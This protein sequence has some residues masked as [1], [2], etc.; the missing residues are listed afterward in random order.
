[1]N[2][3]RDML[4]GLGL[5]GLASTPTILHPYWGGEGAK[6]A[7]GGASLPDGSYESFGAGDQVAALV[8]EVAPGLEGPNPLLTLARRDLIIAVDL[9]WV[10]VP[11][12]RSNAEVAELGAKAG[13]YAEAKGRPGWLDEV[14]NDQQF[15]T[16]LAVEVDAWQPQATSPVAATEWES[17]GVAD[18]WDRVREGASRLVSTPSRVVGSAAVAAGRAKAQS[19]VALFLGDV[20]IYLDRR[21]DNAGRPGPITQVVIDAV[22][23]ALD[24][25]TPADPHLVLMGH[26][27]GGN[28]L[29]DIL[30]HY[31]PNLSV[32]AL[33]TVGSQ[34][35]F[36][37]EL[38]LFQS[39]D[40]SIPSPTIVK[41]ALRSGIRHWLN[42]FDRQD[43][44]SFSGRAIFDRI[45]D[46]DYSTGA[47]VLGAHTTYLE[48]PSFHRRLN[49]RLHAALVP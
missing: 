8:E 6:P 4:A 15:L 40:A 3:Q 11:P 23:Q 1:M 26:S 24:A 39:S 44:L 17:F 46:L 36:F 49:E 19:A 47:S 18:V 38:K 7:W 41:Q 25:V 12:D 45:E 5:R 20:L 28:I 37:E 29:Y 13:T 34:V 9:L 31:R 35:P 33:V 16:R 48:R 22:D 14:T 2:K 42:I 27:M 32:D 21:D 43:I 30:T 10:L